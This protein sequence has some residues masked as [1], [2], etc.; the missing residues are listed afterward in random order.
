[1]MLDVS[2]KK[3]KKKDPPLEGKEKFKAILAAIALGIAGY[4]VFLD[5]D[6]PLMTVQSKPSGQSLPRFSNKPDPNL[7]QKIY[8]EG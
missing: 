7:S 1:M 5:T 2:K 8:L 4:M 6:P 3:A